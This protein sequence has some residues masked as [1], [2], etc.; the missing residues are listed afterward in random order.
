LAASLKRSP[1]TNQYFFQLHH[2]RPSL[3]VDS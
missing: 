1:V 2:Y 3:Y